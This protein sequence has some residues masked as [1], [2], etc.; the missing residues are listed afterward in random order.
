[1]QA[2]PAGKSALSWTFDLAV[3][4]TGA[5]LAV[6]AFARFVGSGTVDA[7]W[8]ATFVVGV[9]LIALMARFPLQLSRAGVGIEV[10]FES[11][12]LVAL[13]VQGQAWGALAVWAAGQTL[14]QVTKRKRVDV[15]LFN[16]S[17]TV[18]C[19][20]AA[21]GV[22][23][24]ID[25]LGRTSVTELA[26]V[27]AG[28]TVFFVVDYVISAAS[29]AFEER[30]SLAEQLRY[31]NGLIAGLAFVGIDSLGYLA[32]LVARTLPGWANALL[33]VPLA[34][35][36]VASRALSRG[37][38]HQRRLTT[39]FD[40]SGAVQGAA[41]KEDVLKWL[42]LQAEK[43]LAK[44]QVTLRFDA[45]SEREV[46]AMLDDD[47]AP[48][49][50]V[51]RTPGLSRSAR[52]LDR[53]A[54]EAL[55]GVGEQVLARLALVE[56][57]ARQARQDSLTGLPNRALFTERLEVA[58]ASASATRQVA[59]LYLDLDGFKSVNDRFGHAAGDE[60]LRIVAE[61]LAA[62]AGRRGCVARLGGDEFA[63]LLLDVTD[64]EQVEAVCQRVLAAVRREA[65]VAGH[66]VLVGTSIG[67]VV[68]SGGEEAPEVMRNADMAMYSA[69][70][71]GKSQY[72]IYEGSLRDD[73]ILRLELIEALRA[74]IERELVVHYQP[75][76][77]LESGRIAG[78]E[79]LVRWRRGG[80][81]VPPDLF[82]PAAEDSGLI[83]PLGQRVLAQVVTDI[84]QL[85]AAAGRPIDLA[86]NMSAHQLHDPDFVGHVRAAVASFGA[87]RLVLEMTETV[88]VQ[89]DPH[90]AET[91]HRLTSAGARL[92]IDDFGVGFSSIGYLQHLPVDIL[93]ID[94]SFVRDIDAR[95][96]ARALVDAIL[97]MASALELD[98]VAEGIERESQAEVLRVA[99]CTEG[100][101]YL[102]AR[103]QPLDEV[104]QTLR[105]GVARVVAADLD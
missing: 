27:G 4:T 44:Q 71:L 72:A 33:I 97:V 12:V 57:L 89:D 2:A 39:L 59:V 16:A 51:T 40:A 101:G 13:V 8:L 23:Y 102:Y 94:R 10:G 18:L 24:A 19:G 37:S 35:I 88:L 65:V 55:A 22:M 78:V 98:V 34:T 17:L 60:L 15:R 61:R 25:P 5:A 26:A 75:V 11:A 56:Q 77:S 62:L 45:P 21:V 96:R 29:V 99:G 63:V 30:T 69:K 28:C 7:T 100:Q 82:I 43:V 6:N 31:S 92:A 86:V 66:G 76:I 64:V 54:L 80:S 47:G 90:T 84:P 81:L 83:V 73:R 79:A 1:M 46:G 32:A 36:L 95:P 67:V 87:S 68:S 74:G 38:E 48:L 50:L 9:P 105:A 58:L 49:W 20:S 53:Q 42:P 70:G 93:K 91:L 85:V 52:D 14:A 41:T 103:P 3:V 104:L